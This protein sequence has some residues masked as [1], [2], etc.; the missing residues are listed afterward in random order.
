[1]ESDHHRLVE[2]KVTPVAVVRGGGR[3]E[4]ALRELSRKVAKPASVKVGFLEKSKY[5]DGTPVAMIAALNEYGVPSRGQ[6]PRPFFRRMIAAKQGEWPSAIAGFLRDNDLD[7]EKA[8]DLAGAAIAGQLRESIRN[9]TDPPLSPS[10]I[11]R[12]GSAKPLVDTG[13]MFNSVDHEVMA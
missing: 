11:R 2:G 3:L 5:P 7:A 8:L 6:P 9:L 10:T 1:V 12:K 4:E 13:H